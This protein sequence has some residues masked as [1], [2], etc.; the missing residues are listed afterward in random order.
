MPPE[1]VLKENDMSYYETREPGRIEL[2]DLAFKFAAFVISALL[3][4]RMLMKL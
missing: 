3:Y 4:A 2:A 1:P